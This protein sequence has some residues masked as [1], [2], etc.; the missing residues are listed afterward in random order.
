MVELAPFL[1]L[2]TG[3]PSAFM[4]QWPYG[5]RWMFVY[6]HLLGTLIFF[7]LHNLLLWIAGPTVLKIYKVQ[8]NKQAPPELVQ[9]CIKHDIFGQG[10]LPLPA[11]YYLLWWTIGARYD[12][13]TQV[14]GALTWIGYIVLYHI[15]FDAWF[16]WAHRL[17]HHPK[18]YKHVHKKH[19]RFMVSQGIAAV[20]AHPLEDIIV[21]AGSTFI[22]PIL[23]PSHVLIAALYFALRLQETVDAHSGY[24]APWS[25]WRYMGYFHGGA[26]RHDFHHS[27][28]VGNYGAFF[29]WDYFMGT[30][31]AYQKWLKQ[32]EVAAK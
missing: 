2:F 1:V 3:G 17:A 10:I 30:D 25:A 9:D 23:F 32:Q 15:L 12:Y 29:Y 13:S 22:G 19:H 24:Q 20:Y 31:K 7:W 18:L 6:L 26:K 21:N 11:F 14:P 5:D 27:H 4:E 16:Y 8:P 28:N